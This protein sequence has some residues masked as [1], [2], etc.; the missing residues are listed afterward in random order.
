MLKLEKI[1]DHFFDSALRTIMFRYA[2]NGGST[3]RDEQKKLI[4]CHVFRQVLTLVTGK[5]STHERCMNTYANFAG[6]LFPHV[7]QDYLGSYIQ[8]KL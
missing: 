8:W 6:I 5:F 4:L 7:L 3:E 1:L 2:V